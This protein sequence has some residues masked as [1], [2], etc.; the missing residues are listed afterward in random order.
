MRGT[1]KWLGVAASLLLGAAGAAYAGGNMRIGVPILP[2]QIGN[3]YQSITLPAV[4]SQ[5]ALFDTLTTL[6]AQG[7]AV[8]AL[9]L[10]WEQESP[11][12]W[13][14]KLRPG[15]KF[16]NGEELTS[17]ALVVSVAH[18]NSQLGRS[19]TIGSTLYQFEHAEA[20]D[21]LT[22]RIVLSE[23]DP[24]FAIHTSVWRIPP[25]KLWQ[26]LGS[27]KYPFNPVGSGPFILESAAKNRVV[28]KANKN[29]WRAP[30]LDTLTLLWAQ[31]EIA[32]VQAFVSG[33]IDVAYNLDPESRP[34]IEGIG[35]EFR[36]RLMPQTWFIAFNTVL[37]KSP[38]KDPRVRKALNL[39]VNRQAIVDQVLKKSVVPAGQ[40]AFLGAFGFDPDMKALPY[41][42]DAAKKLLVQAG[43]ANGFKI[44]MGA[45]ISNS[46]FAQAFQ[47]AALDL[48]KVGVEFE[49]QMAPAGKQTQD[50]F[51]GQLK[52]D[53]F[54]MFARGN[55][56]I[57]DYRHRSCLT[58]VKERQPYHC[59]PKVVDLV[60]RGIAEQ[61]LDKRRAI[62]SEVAKAEQ[63]S[64]PGILLWQGVEFDGISSKVKTYSPV[65]DVLNLHE[66]DMK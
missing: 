13:V 48:K 16:S 8:P 26:E 17:E 51:Y 62:Y 63:E 6:D 55:D 37:E 60:R 5:Q 2:A 57:N 10:S 36:T 47:L 21:P 49:I 12:S 50:M 29:S 23:P 18:M 54:N 46:T 1:V 35:G 15:V 3:P 20:I 40:L 19:E 27:E 61:D 30:K 56:P 39:A 4:F 33:A 14:V 24:L 64:P 11:L 52:V 28:L 66:W 41:D 22:A 43:Y 53:A 7:N 9:A 45:A 32:R 59:D 38:L 44:V 34:E 25:P 58:F 65:Q 42:P 31:D